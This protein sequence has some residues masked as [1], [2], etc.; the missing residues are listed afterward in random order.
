MIKI[1]K[2][3]FIGHLGAGLPMMASMAGLGGAGGMAVHPDAMGGTV[4][5]FPYNLPYPAAYVRVFFCSCVYGLVCSPL[6][7]LGIWWQHAPAFF[8]S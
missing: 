5:F 4:P 8:G 1:P 6:L 2:R 3:F 7:C